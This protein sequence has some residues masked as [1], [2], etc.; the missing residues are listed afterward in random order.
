[1][2]IIVHS[3][4][5]PQDKNELRKKVAMV[6]A[7]AVIQYIGKLFCPEEQRMKLHDEIKKVHHNKQQVAKSD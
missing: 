6:H 3:P 2:N 4:K 1:M 7:E 5:N